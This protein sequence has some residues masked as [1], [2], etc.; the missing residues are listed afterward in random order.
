MLLLVVSQSASAFARALSDADRECIAA[1]IVLEAGGQPVV[2]MQ[3]VFNVIAARAV[4]DPAKLMAVVL[5]P[6]QFDV[7]SGISGQDVPDWAPILARARAHSKFAAA[8]RIVAS[9]EA[10]QL[11]DVTGGCKYFLTVGTQRIWTK[12]LEMGPML[13]K[14]QFYRDPA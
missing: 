1:V 2:V 3:G 9:W 4:H 14:L 5:K 8:L 7:L 6:R 10:N 11:A 12:A 13:G